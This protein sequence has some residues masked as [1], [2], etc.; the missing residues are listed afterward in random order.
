MRIRNI[1][2]SSLLS[3]STTI[4]VIIYFVDTTSW[5]EGISKAL[6][7]TSLAL[8]GVAVLTAITNMIITLATVTE[9]EKYSYKTVLLFK[10]INI[11]FFIVNFVIYTLILILPL[12]PWLFILAIPAFFVVC[13]GVCATYILMLATS[14]D[15]VRLIIKK[16]IR[17]E[18]KIVDQL[19]PL[20][21][22]F[23][24]V[25]DVIGAIVACVIDSKS[26]KKKT[27]K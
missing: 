22:S 9:K 1:I 19:F 6:L 11:P 24:M 27:I 26:K 12:N 21:A 23:L 10:L 13:F 2:L 7:I 5:P 14:L 8:Y 3:I 17:K 16:Q 18:G 15:L 4:T 20:I 25:F